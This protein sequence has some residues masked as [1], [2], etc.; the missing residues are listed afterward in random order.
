MQRLQLGPRSAHMPDERLDAAV[1]D[2]WRNGHIVQRF[3]LVRKVAMDRR[4]LL[5]KA[6]RII[7]WRGGR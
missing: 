4:L 5:A 7:L 6:E 1:I 3:D 2:V